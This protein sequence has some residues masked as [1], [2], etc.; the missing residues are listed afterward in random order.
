MSVL[1][2]VRIS[3]LFS[4]NSSARRQMISLLWQRSEPKIGRMRKSIHKRSVFLCIGS[5]V[6]SAP[7]KSYVFRD[8]YHNTNTYSINEWTKER[9]TYLMITIVFIFLKTMW[10][11]MWLQ[12]CQ[13]SS[14]DTC[15]FSLVLGGWAWWRVRGQGQ[16][17]LKVH[18]VVS[19]LLGTPT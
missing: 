14:R 9:Q 1:L 17:S 13:R 4:V 8:V 11:L 12:R 6:S 7:F 2:A 18:S 19:L 5:I 16:T 3:S 15:H 10:H